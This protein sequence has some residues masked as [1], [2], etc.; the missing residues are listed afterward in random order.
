MWS[1]KPFKI[2]PF[3]DFLIKLDMKRMHLVEKEFFWTKNLKNRI[4]RCSR[5]LFII[6]VSLTVTLFIG[7]MLISTRYICGLMPNLIKKN[8]ERYLFQNVAYLWK[9]GNAF[10]SRLLAFALPAKLLL[11]WLMKKQIFTSQNH[12]KECFFL[13]VIVMWTRKKNFWKI[14]QWK[15]H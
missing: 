13:Y 15:M 7:K 6:L 14:F 4:L 11:W 5:R 10:Q 1:M 9:G 8:L 2:E 12:D 3:Q